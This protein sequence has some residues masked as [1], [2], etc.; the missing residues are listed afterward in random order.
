MELR[1]ERDLTLGPDTDPGARVGD[2]VYGTRAGPWQPVDGQYGFT[3]RGEKV[4]VHLLAGYEGMEFT[5]PPFDAPV[6]RCID[7]ARNQPLEFHQQP[8]GTVVIRN[9]DRTAHPANT[10]L[11]IERQAD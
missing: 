9:I 1:C 5:T 3:T 8:D 11:M 6:L 7:L 2:A 10:V 4:F